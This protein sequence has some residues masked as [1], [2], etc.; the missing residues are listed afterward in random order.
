MKRLQRVGKTKKNV[1]TT[2]RFS[3][4]DVKMITRTKEIKNRVM[5]SESL[6]KNIASSTYMMRKTF[7]MLTHD[8]RII[9]VNTDNQQKIIRRIEKQ[10]EKL[11]SKLKIVK[12]I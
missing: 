7:E 4:E 12:M 8:V 10:N 6:T 1:L 11:H 3:S 5:I 2:R 9:D